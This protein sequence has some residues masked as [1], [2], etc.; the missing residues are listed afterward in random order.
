MNVE[1]GTAAVQFL[2]WEY[3]FWI[4]GV[5]SLQ[6]C[7]WH[8]Y[9]DPGFQTE[10]L[11]AKL[12]Q[13]KRKN[14]LQSL[15]KFDESMAKKHNNLHSLW[16][17]TRC[18]NPR[19]LWPLGMIVV[20]DSLPVSIYSQKRMPIQICTNPTTRLLLRTVTARVNDHGQTFLGSDWSNP[21]VQPDR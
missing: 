14:P 4:F 2:F 6:G 19:R 1:I 5:V 13:I 20:E 7:I 21:P 10:V 12:M 16:G 17:W 9:N 8:I 18:E 11:I 15:A 3:L